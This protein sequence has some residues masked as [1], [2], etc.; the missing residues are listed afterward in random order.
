MPKGRVYA[1]IEHTEDDTGGRK[2]YIV[3]VN[4]EDDR[5]APTVSDGKGYVIFASGN[6]YHGELKDGQ[7]N[8]YG[9][10]IYAN[11]NKHEGEWRDGKQHG[12]VTYTFANGTNK[13][14]KIEGKY[15]DGK[16]HGSFI[17]T[18]I[19]GTKNIREFNNGEEK[20]VVKSYTT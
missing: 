13:V 17:Y 3:H 14:D 5:G 18:Y 8:G 15:K 1:Y 16:R 9:T 2:G 19:N 11:G 7:R 10:T 4:T 12:Q 20:V 6:Y